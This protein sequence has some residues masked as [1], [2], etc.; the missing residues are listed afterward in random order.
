MSATKAVFTVSS[1][2]FVLL[3][4]GGVLLYMNFGDIAKKIAQKI[5]SETLGVTVSIGKIDVALKEKTVTV[6]KVKVGNPEGY[7]G[8][9]AA[10]IETIYL[11]ADT[12]SQALLRFNDISVTGSEVYLEVRE[13]GT[14]LTDIKKTVNA[15]AAK[16]DKAAQQIKVIIER[17]KIEE[18][19]VHPSVLLAGIGDMQPITL[20][21]IKLNGIGVKE[22]GVLAREAIGQIWQSISSE[23]SKSANS[24]GFYQGVSPEALEDIGVSQIETFKENFKKDIGNLKKSIFGE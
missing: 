21:P 1:L 23:V 13:T 2:A 7:K 12:L 22:N 11:K 15:K 24:A 3:F 10:T 18:M 5:A 16:G 17:M 8:P 20:P 6:S 4:G 14:N 19:R 9:H